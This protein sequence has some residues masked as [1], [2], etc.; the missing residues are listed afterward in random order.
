[1]LKY[2]NVSNPNPT[3]I[4]FC[5]REGG[6]CDTLQPEGRWTSRQSFWAFIIRGS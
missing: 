3:H 6:N 2:D 5:T 4:L 1:M